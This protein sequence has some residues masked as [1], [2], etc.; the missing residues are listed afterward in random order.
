M[1]LVRGVGGAEVP[2]A[3]QEAERARYVVE[4]ALQEKK[5]IIVKAQGEAKAAELVGKAMQNNPCFI[6]LRKI[7]TA[8]DIASTIARAQSKVFL[9]SDALLLNLLGDD[10]LAGDVKKKSSSFF[11]K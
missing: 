1:D 6:K 3:Q 10:Q 9:N 2:V 7:D 8:K 4:K 5:S 11:G